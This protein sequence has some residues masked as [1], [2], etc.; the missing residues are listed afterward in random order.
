[1]DS[2]LYEQ[3]S[4]PSPLD[5][6]PPPSGHNGSYPEDQECN[7]GEAFIDSSLSINK[8]AAW[9]TGEAPGR[10]AD[11]LGDKDNG[12]DGFGEDSCGPANIPELLNSRFATFSW[13]RRDGPL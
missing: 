10:T 6:V 8:V 9:V 12:I 2:T 7:D 1:M 5:P 3:L 4:I 13:T 11:L